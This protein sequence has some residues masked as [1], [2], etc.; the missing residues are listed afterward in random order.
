[1]LEAEEDSSMVGVRLPTNKKGL[2]A[3]HNRECL[4]MIVEEEEII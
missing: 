3:L 4:E 2:A 1:V